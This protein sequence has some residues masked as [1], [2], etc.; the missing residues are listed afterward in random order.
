MS[1]NAGMSEIETLVTRARI[2]AGTSWD[3]ADGGHGN[4]TESQEP[5]VRNILR[6]CASVIE[7]LVREHRAFA[8]TIDGV[9]S[10][11]GQ[12]A[13]HYLVVADDVRELVEAVER[14]ADDGGCRA[15]QVLRGL[16]KR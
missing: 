14:C 8:E 12:E 4:R 1:K 11:L 6:E 15:A 7:I 10:A 5:E 16:R 2:A 13:T 3:G 9:R